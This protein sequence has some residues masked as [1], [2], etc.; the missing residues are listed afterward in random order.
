MHTTRESAFRQ[1]IVQQLATQFLIL[2]AVGAASC[3]V[4]YQSI[5]QSFNFLYKWIG[6]DHIRKISLV[7]AAIT[8][9][10]IPEGWITSLY[11]A[12]CGKLDLLP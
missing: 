1:W 4:R 8:S 9:Y 2:V 5:L 12:L 7:D 11:Y 6:C 10:N 3:S